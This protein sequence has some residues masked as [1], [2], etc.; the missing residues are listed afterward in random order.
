VCCR[1]SATDNE[2]QIQWRR[3]FVVLWSLLLLTA[4]H[5]VLATTAAIAV[6]EAFTCPRCLSASA[7]YHSNTI[8]RCHARVS[9]CSADIRSGICAAASGGSSW[10]LIH[11][12][13]PHTATGSDALR[14]TFLTRLAADVKVRQFRAWTIRL[15]YEVYYSSYF[16]YLH[17][18]S[19]HRA[20]LLG[21][22]YLS[23]ATAFV[24]KEP[25]LQA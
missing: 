1:H 12:L 18:V 19:T 24:S 6:A 22:L 17:V 5:K 23:A 14:R 2:K 20:S 9:H 4:Q 25:Q 7:G 15:R 3:L 10:L 11:L 8:S 13:L 16:P 21:R